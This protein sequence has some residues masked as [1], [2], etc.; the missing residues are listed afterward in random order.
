[1]ATK[2]ENVP[3]QVATVSA[4]TFAHETAKANY[5]EVNAKTGYGVDE[6]FGNAVLAIISPKPQPP[7]AAQQQQQQQQGA[8][9]N[10]Q[11]QPQQQQGTPQPAAAAAKQAKQQPAGNNAAAAGAKPAEP[12]ERLPDVTGKPWSYLIPWPTHAHDQPVPIAILPN[13]FSYLG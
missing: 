9:P 3:R 2:C 1:V 8:Q 6:L 7:P 4:Q 5:R 11:Q 12:T 13:D 10:A